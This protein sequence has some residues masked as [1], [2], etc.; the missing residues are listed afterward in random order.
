MILNF[1]GRAAFKIRF[2]FSVLSVSWWD[3]KGY[4]SDVKIVS[5]FYIFI[6]IILLPLSYLKENYTHNGR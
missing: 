2:E 4:F 1:F 3:F 6:Y 5:F